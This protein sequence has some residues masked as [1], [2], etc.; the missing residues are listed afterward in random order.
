M[1]CCDYSKERESIGA[2][3]EGGGEGKNGEVVMLSRGVTVLHYVPGTCI[4][5][6]RPIFDQ[7]WGG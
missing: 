2:L 3:E 5:V 1:L 6:L 7:I 4:H